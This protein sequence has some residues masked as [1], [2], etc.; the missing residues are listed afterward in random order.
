MRKINRSEWYDLEKYTLAKSFDDFKDKYRSEDSLNMFDISENFIKNNLFE[1]KGDKNFIKEPMHFITGIWWSWKSSFINFL[2]LNIK[3]WYSWK[4]YSGDSDFNSKKKIDKCIPIFFRPWN[5]QKSKDIYETFFW[6][7]KDRLLQEKYSHKIDDWFW[8]LLDIL[9]DWW[10]LRSLLKYFKK[11]ENDLDT[12]LQSITESLKKDYADKLFI[13]IIDEIDR[14]DKD[15]MKQVV[16]LMWVLQKLVFLNRETSNIII[17][18]SVDYNYLQSFSLSD[19]CSK[20]IT[21]DK[22]FEKFSEWNFIDVYEVSKSWLIDYLNKYIFSWKTSIDYSKSYEEWP[23]RLGRLIEDVQ[24]SWHA[25][26]IRNIANLQEKVDKV[27]EK[28]DSNSQKV[29]SDIW[30]EFISNEKKNKIT[31]DIVDALKNHETKLLLIY[32]LSFGIY[33]KV[34]FNKINKFLEENECSLEIGSND[35]NWS[36]KNEKRKSFDRGAVQP[37]PV[38]TFLDIKEGKKWISLKHVKSLLENVGLDILLIDQAKSAYTKIYSNMIM[39]SSSDTISDN[40]ITYFFTYIDKSIGWYRDHNKLFWWR[41]RRY[42]L[43]TQEKKDRLKLYTFLIEKFTDIVTNTEFNRNTKK[44]AMYLVRDLIAEI[45][46]RWYWDYIWQTESETALGSDEEKFKQ[47]IRNSTIQYI[48]KIRLAEDDKLIACYLY[49]ITHQLSKARIKGGGGYQNTEIALKY[50]LDTC[51][52]IE[53]ILNSTE[54]QEDILKLTFMST[55]YTLTISREIISKEEER[56]K[57]HWC[58]Y[59]WCRWVQLLDDILSEGTFPSLDLWLSDKTNFL[60]T[61]ILSIFSPWFFNEEDSLK[62]A[63]DIISNVSDEIKIWYI[64][65]FMT[66]WQFDD[67]RIKFDFDFTS[68]IV[69]KLVDYIIKE[70][71]L[72]LDKLLNNDLEIAFSHNSIITYYSLEKISKVNKSRSVERLKEGIIDLIK[73]KKDDNK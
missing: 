59:L 30:L 67:L 31:I 70:V 50:I 5:Y 63:K 65:L 43:N 39:S 15:E 23:T 72:E 17:L 21:Y 24:Q 33:Q 42:F 25:I 22:Y 45:V 14:I 29:F 38:L 61:I 36:N 62:V 2:L 47:D 46:E 20:S 19:N 34:Y 11:Y 69:R 58:F 44:N 26:N 71:P 64:C 6:I 18:Y 37:N 4:I 28:I 66:L 57:Y 54:V 10:W 12:L 49:L 48:D 55:K 52:L 35:N 51:G 56:K 16:K 60:S 32:F 73:K 40:E 1:E 9:S 41:V 3:Y 68:D 8:K 53:E 27:L 13:I 7:L